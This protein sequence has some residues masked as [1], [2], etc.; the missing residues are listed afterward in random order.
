M[1]NSYCP[2]QILKGIIYIGTVAEEF[3]IV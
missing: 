2:Q 1:K 3:S